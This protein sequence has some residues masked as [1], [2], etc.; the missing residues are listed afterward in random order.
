[1]HYN[2][3]CVALRHENF[4]SASRV[5]DITMRDFI[6]TFFNVLPAW[7]ALAL[8]PP[9]A[10]ASEVERR[11]HRRFAYAYIQLLADLVRNAAEP[12]LEPFLR[13]DLKNTVQFAAFM[14]NSTDGRVLRSAF[15]FL[16][17]FLSR[18]NREFDKLV[19]QHKKFITLFDVLIPTGEQVENVVSTGLGDLGATLYWVLRNLIVVEHPIALTVMKRNALG[20]LAAAVGE[21]GDAQSLGL[22]YLGALLACFRRFSSRSTSQALLQLAIALRTAPFDDHANA[23]ES[24]RK[25]K[26]AQQMRDLKSLLENLK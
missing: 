23:L 8:A 9:S 18:E 21:P 22:F 14:L 16:G 4:R 15:S 7:S 12:F 11:T 19:L 5:T 13:P 26:H 10:S 3:M 17:T 25:P 24:V 20:T 2:A 1:M 6:S